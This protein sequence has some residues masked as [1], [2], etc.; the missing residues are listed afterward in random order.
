MQLM[1][2][3][4]KKSES[5]CLHFSSGPG[6][7]PGVYRS[8]AGVASDPPPVLLGADVGLLLRTKLEGGVSIRRPALQRE[9]VVPGNEYN[10]SSLCLIVKLLIYC[11]HFD[12]AL[13]L[14]GN[15]YIPESCHLE[16][17]TRGR[18]DCTG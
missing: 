4:L 13:S 7:V 16:H 2:L 6:E 11:I 17:V 1:V 12:V 14:S 8:T 3:L 15:L 18:S 9:Q 10:L 5:P